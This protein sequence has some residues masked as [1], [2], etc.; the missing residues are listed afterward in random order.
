MT[1]DRPA[2]PVPGEG[3]SPLF[4]VER[5]YVGV[6]RVACRDCGWQGPGRDIGSRLLLFDQNAHQKCV[7]PATEPEPGHEAENEPQ[8]EA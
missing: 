2:G 7:A 5:D 1:G 8:A 4:R 3:T 6:Y